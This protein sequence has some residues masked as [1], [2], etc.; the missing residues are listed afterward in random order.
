VNIRQIAAQAPAV[1]KA[2]V[3][4]GI[5]ILS[6]DSPGRSPPVVLYD[7]ASMFSGK[8][9]YEFIAVKDFT[10]LR[11]VLPEKS[12]PSPYLW[13]SKELSAMS[14][15]RNSSLV[16]NNGYWRFGDSSEIGELPQPHQGAEKFLEGHPTIVQ[17]HVRRFPEPL[18]PRNY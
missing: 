7:F 9:A 6:I 10:S 14:F 2:F 17:P 16:S 8:R 4:L 3:F 12:E 1:Q 11:I 5:E 18:Q 15:A 13:K